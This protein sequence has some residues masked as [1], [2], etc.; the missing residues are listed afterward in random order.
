M[1]SIK[2]ESRP[3]TLLPDNSKTGLIDTIK[4]VQNGKIKDINVHIDISHSF[5]SDLEVTLTAPSGQKVPLHQRQGGR[6]KDLK[7]KYDKKVLEN[8][9][10]TEVSGHWKLQ[11]KDLAP[12]DNGRLNSW[13]IRL[14]CSGSVS[15]IFVPAK[16]VAINSVQDCQ[17]KGRVTDLK[18]YVNLEHPSSGAVQMA[19]VAPS[20]KTVVVHDYSGETDQNITTTFKKEALAEMLGQSTHGSWTLMVKDRSGKKRGILKKWKL[21]FKYQDV[22]DLKKME[23]IGPKIEQL[24]NAENIYSW[25]RLSVTNPSRIREILAAAG[26]RFRMHDPTTWPQQAKMAAAG[27]WEKL[28]KWQDELDGGRLN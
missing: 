26:D 15:E 12:K 17:V 7:A 8:L 3:N 22:N 1:Y 16:S 11:V 28:K 27:E 10:N 21:E 2:K 14:K 5:I 19:L 6:D 18:M 24:L 25:S 13:G 23:G 9:L 4:I 20:G